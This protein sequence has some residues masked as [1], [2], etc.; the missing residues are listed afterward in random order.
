VT[1]AG[2]HCK[3]GLLLHRGNNVFAGVPASCTGLPKDE[4]TDQSGCSAAA[5]PIGTPARVGG[6]KH[7]AKLFYNSFGAMALRGER[8]PDQCSYNDLA[9]LKLK[10]A[11]AKRA[12]GAI[13]GYDSPKRV[14]PHGPANGSRVSCTC[15]SAT[16]GTIT[17]SG[18]RYNLS[19][20]PTVTASDVGTPFMQGK[21]L[22]GMLTRLP[23]G[24]PLLGTDAAISN[25]H[26]ALR[27]ARQA[28]RLAVLHHRKL[29]HLKLLKA[30]QH[31]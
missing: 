7:S 18:W 28:P 24:P 21:R 26:R 2:V 11:D 5:A 12:L 29:T 16:A 15:G 9:L 10:H 20:A 23:Q 27:L 8:D 31:A 14:S 25:L 22:V 13:P 3:V 6:A 17:H 30:G 4:G 1:I 19:A